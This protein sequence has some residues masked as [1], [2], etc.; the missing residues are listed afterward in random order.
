MQSL[1]FQ[2]MLCG[3]FQDTD[4]RRK[5]QSVIVCNI[6]SGGTQT[7]SVQN[8]AHQVA[9]R[10][11]DGSRTVPGLHH[12]RIVLIEIA[13]LLGNRII[14]GPGLR[15]CNHDRKRQLHSAHYQKFQCIVQHCGVR[16]ICIDYR[17]HLR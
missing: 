15:D 9:V 11:Q 2:N 8:S 6:I 16:S 1:F 17:K 5:D 14:V 3:N 10:K 7:V 13:S 4:F 12:R